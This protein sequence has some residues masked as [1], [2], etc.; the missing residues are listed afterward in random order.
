M[1]RIRFKTYH[2][3]SLQMPPTA[4]TKQEAVEQAKGLGLPQKTMEDWLKK[5]LQRSNIE[6]VLHSLYKKKTCKSAY[7]VIQ[8]FQVFHHLSKPGKPE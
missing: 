6:R 4:F 7:Q 2:H 3:F 8:V 1:S 5:S